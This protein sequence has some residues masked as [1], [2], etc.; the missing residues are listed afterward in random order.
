MNI[1]VPLIL[2]YYLFNSAEILCFLVISDVKF[3]L[4]QKEFCYF[5]KKTKINKIAILDGERSNYTGVTFNNALTN[6]IFTKFTVELTV[7]II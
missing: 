7:Y 3:G 5:G 6:T 1:S 2:S 4:Y